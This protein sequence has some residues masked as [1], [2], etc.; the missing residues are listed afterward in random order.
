M[1]KPPTNT[2]PAAEPIT[3]L[4]CSS[5]IARFATDDDRRPIPTSNTPAHTILTGGDCAL[6]YCRS[7][8]RWQPWGYLT[9]TPGDL[10]AAHSRAVYANRARRQ[11]P[12]LTNAPHC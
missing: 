6:V 9:A 1:T 12:R 4:Q 5:I 2:A 3:C 7:C 10:K 11:Q 8:Q